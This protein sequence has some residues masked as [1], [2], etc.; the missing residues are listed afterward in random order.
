MNENSALRVFSFENKQVRVVEKDGEPWWVLKDVC[1]VLELSNSRMVADRL[2]EDEKGVSITDTLGG[3]RETTVVSE[4]GLY[5]VSAYRPR[6]T[7]GSGS[8]RTRSGSRSTRLRA[9]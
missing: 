1:D 2:D 6:S 3:E 4:S 5:S 7:K 8:G 9:S